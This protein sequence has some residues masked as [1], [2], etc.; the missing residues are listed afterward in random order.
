MIFFTADIHLLHPSVI[1]FERRPFATVEEMDNEIIYRWN[2]IIEE[3][4]EVYIIGDVYLGNKTEATALIKMLKGKKYLINGNHDKLNTEQKSLFV[5]VKDYYKLRVNDKR[6][7]LFHYP[8]Y[9]W[10]G[11][12]KGY[13]HLHG[14]SHTTSHGDI[15]LKNKV[16]VGMDLWNYT[17]VSMDKILEYISANQE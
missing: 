10:D 6:F 2:N 16:N 13:I 5:W 9:E 7:I 11:K 15:K 12:T 17:P 8:I 14:H 4:D 1:E 3:N